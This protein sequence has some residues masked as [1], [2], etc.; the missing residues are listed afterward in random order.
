VCPRI[1]ESPL[2][3]SQSGLDKLY[4]L[5]DAPVTPTIINK[6]KLAY[7]VRRYLDPLKASIPSH[8]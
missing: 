8:T 1:S 7:K 6:G 5:L 4:S 3:R 2:L